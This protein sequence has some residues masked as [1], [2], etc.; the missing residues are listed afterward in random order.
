MSVGLRYFGGAVAF[1][2][3]AMLITASLA[4]ALVCLSSAVLGVAVVSAAERT[5]AKLAKRVGGHAASRPS[6]AVPASKIPA[7]EGLPQWADA[8]NGDLGHIYDPA[9]AMAPLSRDAEYGWPLGDDT[10]ITTGTL[11]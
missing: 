8:I 4:A 9:A 1:G 11:H 5:R 7:A 10:V 3:A 2:F 6:T